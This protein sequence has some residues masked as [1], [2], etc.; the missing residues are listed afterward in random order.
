MSDSVFVDPITTSRTTRAV[1]RNAVVASFVG[2]KTIGR[3]DCKSRRFVARRVNG[4]V[5]FVA[6]IIFSAVAS[7]HK[8]SDT[9]I[10]QS[11]D[12]TTQHVVFVRLDSGSSETKID[13]PDVV[14]AGMCGHPIKT[15]QNT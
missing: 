11:A 7:G 14:L 8:H 9:G 4:A 13:Y 15:G 3:S 12:G 5:N 10:H 2:L 1:S 6:G